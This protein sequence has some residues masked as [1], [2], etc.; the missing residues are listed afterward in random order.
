LYDQEGIVFVST[1]RHCR[2]VFAVSPY[3]ITSPFI[4]RAM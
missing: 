2:S 4:Y 3:P 1:W